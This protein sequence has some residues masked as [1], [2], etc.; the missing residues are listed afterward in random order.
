MEIVFKGAQHKDWA[1]PKRTT[2]D[3]SLRNFEHYTRAWLDRFLLGDT[4]AT[5]RLLSATVNG[6]AASAILSTQF[7]SAA[8]LDGTDCGDLRACLG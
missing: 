4:T 8:F 1:Q 2:S 7:R 3:T 5:Q 6:L